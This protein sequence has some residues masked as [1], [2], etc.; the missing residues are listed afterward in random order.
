MH[1]AGIMTYK[2]IASGYVHGEDQNTAAWGWFHDLGGAD[3][4]EVTNQS[5]SAWG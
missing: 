4:Y 1:E 2:S 3:L 5:D